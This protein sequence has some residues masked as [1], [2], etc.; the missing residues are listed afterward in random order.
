MLFVHRHAH[1]CQTV[2]QDSLRYVFALSSSRWGYLCVWP[3]AEDVLRMTDDERAIR[4]LVDT[5]LAASKADDL[6]TVLSLMTDE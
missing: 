5:W 2:W 3:E 6:A 1:A 4:E